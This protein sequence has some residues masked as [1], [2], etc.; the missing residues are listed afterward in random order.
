MPAIRFFRSMGILAMASSLLA[1]S[2]HEVAKGGAGS[3]APASRPASS[4][5]RGDSPSSAASDRF[6]K[7]GNR[8]FSGLEPEQEGEWKG[9]FFFIV[10][11]D[12][13][14]GFFTGDKDF[15][16]ETELTE[17]AVV[18]INRLN[19]RF[20]IVLGDLTNAVPGSKAYPA[21]VAEFK[22]VFG[23]INA[24]IPILCLPGNHDIYNTPEKSSLG[25]YV[26]NFGDDYYG[27]WCGGVR[28][29]VLNSGLYKDSS[30]VPDNAKKQDEWFKE[31]IRAAKAAHARHIVVFQHHPWFL[32][33]PD[34]DD[35]YYNLPLSLRAPMLDL[36]ETSG[37]RA[38]F[39]G[40]YH[41]EALGAYK[42]MEMATCGPVGKPL[43]QK[44]GT[45]TA[46]KS[47]LRIVKVCADAIEHAYYA[48]DAVPEKV[49]MP[50]S[51][52]S[53]NPPVKSG[54]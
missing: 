20:V 28:G 16:K 38:I 13:Q 27:F 43:W 33:K 41:Q 31:Q 9:P 19:P 12:P 30:K 6:T 46:G 37:A 52:P 11:A 5:A 14:Y 54:K 34:E 39:A 29:L 23:K 25:Q 26:G 51:Q 15:D 40:H 35:Q 45:K 4:S 44:G 36:M 32:Y 7:A 18:H 21:Q 47:G 48:L 50:A 17:K 53:A 2:V 10:I 42:G 8:K 1:Q 3:A 24:A 22:R 49:D